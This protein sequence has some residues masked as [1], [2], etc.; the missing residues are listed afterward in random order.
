M[1]SSK[2]G[3]GFSQRPKCMPV[4]GKPPFSNLLFVI[5]LSW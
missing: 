4:D 1:A 3:K 2:G 5:F